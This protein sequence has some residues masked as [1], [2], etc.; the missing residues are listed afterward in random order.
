[1][2]PALYLAYVPNMNDPI[3]VSISRDYACAIDWEDTD[4]NGTPDRDIVK[5][6]GNTPTVPDLDV[7]SSAQGEDAFPLDPSEWRDTDGDGVGDN[8][9]AFPNDPF[10][11]VDTDNDGVGDNAD[12]FPQDPSESADT[13]GDGIGDNADQLPLDVSETLDTDG[14]G[15]GNNADTDDDNDG[16]SDDADQYR[17]TLLDLRILMG[18]ES[19]M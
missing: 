4:G 14:D 18:M 6:W 16:V 12:H 13:D 17:S 9:D 8:A 5:C 11:T 10:E 2:Q 15:I 3:D 7:T 19:M 1:M